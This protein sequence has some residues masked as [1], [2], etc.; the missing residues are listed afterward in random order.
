MRNVYRSD[1][2]QI[3]GV[4]VCVCVC[5]CARVRAC[6]RAR[7]RACVPKVEKMNHFTEK[8]NTVL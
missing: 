2:E 5:V 3:S 4:C 6:A 8:K 1:L 7:V